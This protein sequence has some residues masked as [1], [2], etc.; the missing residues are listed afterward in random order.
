MLKT[1]FDKFNLYMIKV[2][3]GIIINFSLLF[4]ATIDSLSRLYEKVV[5]TRREDEE[6]GPF[7]QRRTMQRPIT[8]ADVAAAM[9]NDED[10]GRATTLTADTKAL[11]AAADAMWG[12]KAAESI[13]VE[14]RA[15]VEKG[16]QSSEEVEEGA[17]ADEDVIRRPAMAFEAFKPP[18]P[19]TEKEVL[20]IKPRTRSIANILVV[21]AAIAKLVGATA[22][23][24][25]NI[26]NIIDVLDG[27]D[28]PDAAAIM[29]PESS[30]AT[31]AGSPPPPVMT[32]PAVSEPHGGNKLK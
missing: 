8:K 4:M 32:T 22:L 17:G 28:S 23:L 10:A 20:S 14:V 12:G 15:D 30:A 25:A 31:D 16:V 13:V 6:E 11:K 21:P 19:S 27:S 7:D 1:L 3:I 5:I 29:A 24:T 9:F 18:T 2:A 26:A